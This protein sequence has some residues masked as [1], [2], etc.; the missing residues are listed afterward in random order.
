MSDELLFYNRGY[1][2]DLTRTLESRVSQIV[3]QWDRDYILNAS[4]AELIEYLFDQTSLDPPVIRKDS[5]GIVEEGSAQVDVSRNFDYS[6]RTGGGPQYINGQ[7]VTVGLEFDGDGGLFHFRPATSTLSPPYG[8][9]KSNEIFCTITAPQLDPAQTRQRIDRWAAEIEQHLGWL[10]RDVAAHNARLRGLAEQAVTGKK[11]NL[12]KQSEAISALGI[13]L[14]RTSSPPQTFSVQVPRKSLPVVALP[15]TSRGASKP[16]PVLSNAEYEHILRVISDAS[17][18]IER[19]PSAAR[20]MS[21]EELRDILLVALNTHYEGGASGETFNM[22]GKTDILV[23]AE[24]KNVFIAECKIWKGASAIVG[25][26]DQL[27]GYLTWRDTKAAL[28]IFSKNADFSNVLT[29]ADAAVRSHANF[30]RF[31]SKDSETQHRHVFTQKHDKD[32]DFYLAV[33]LVNIP[34]R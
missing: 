6:F 30:K 20:R 21:E 26:I 3:D 7:F 5:L 31:V 1:L 17:V 28:V 19:S 23:R 25:A 13:P 14:K 2:S 33:V 27:L 29:A 9:I 24:G 10:Q 8:T 15:A 16:E 12:L 4:E 18:S 22:E 34:D 32:R 11:A